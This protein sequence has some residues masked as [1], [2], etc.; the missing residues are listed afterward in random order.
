MDPTEQRVHQPQVSR[1]I[2]CS[3]WLVEKQEARPIPRRFQPEHF[4]C[5]QDPLSLALRERADGP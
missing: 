5:E 4:A 1:R 2:G 3:E